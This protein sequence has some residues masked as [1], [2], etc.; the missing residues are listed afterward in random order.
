MRPVTSDILLS[1]W[2]KVDSKDPISGC[3]A[4][5]DHWE[6]GNGWCCTGLRKVD[7][8]RKHGPVR[9]VHSKEGIVEAS[10]RNGKRH[11]FYRHVRTNFVKIA[12][13]QEGIE[14]GFFT[15]NEDFKEIRREGD[16]LWDYT[17]EHFDS[18]NEDPNNYLRL[19]Q[20][21]EQSK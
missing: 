19:L 18:A 20:V 7:S 10:F 14:L 12:L 16:E 4:R 8:G 6:D 5:F 1:S 21:L 17:A 11:G 13:Y 3:T 2:L 9:G 15:F